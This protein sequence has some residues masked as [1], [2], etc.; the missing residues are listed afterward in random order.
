MRGQ[1]DKA[2]RKKPGL[3]P[4]CLAKLEKNARG[5]RFERR[6]LNCRA[7]FQK[8]LKCLDCGTSRVWQGPEGTVCKG[9]GRKVLEGDGWVVRRDLLTAQ[10]V[11][12]CIKA[13]FPE[14]EE[15]IEYDR[16]SVHLSLGELEILANQAIARGDFSALERTYAF[17]LGLASEADRLHPSVLSAIH[18]SFLEGLN[19]GHTRNGEKAKEL[20]PAVLKAMWERQMA[21]NRSI[22]WT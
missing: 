2:R 4:V 20:L 15:A 13:E 21:H 16:D 22:G 6:C 17:V 19:L 7:T 1:D 18:V 11:W 14:L 10:D 12:R 9:C 5:T 3:C 8:M